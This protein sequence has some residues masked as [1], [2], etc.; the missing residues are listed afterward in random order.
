MFGVVVEAFGDDQLEGKA[1]AEGEQS[2]REQHAFLVK[3]SLHA[4]V[5]MNELM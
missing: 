2:E 4:N 1:D 5:G 3:P